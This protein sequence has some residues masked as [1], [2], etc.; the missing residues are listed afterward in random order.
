MS[1]EVLTHII[2]VKHIPSWVP[3][4]NIHSFGTEGRAL[5]SRVVGRPFEHVV[6]QVSSGSARTSF[7]STCLELE[8]TTEMK[9]DIRWAA[10][11]M[12]GGRS[13]YILI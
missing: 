6:Q 9:N 2:P 4:N 12:Y 1:S 8:D 13:K 3:F 11:S 7:S 10:G 5:L